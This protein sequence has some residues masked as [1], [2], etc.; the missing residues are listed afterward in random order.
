[1][2]HSRTYRGGGEPDDFSCLLHAQASEETELDN[3]RLACQSQR[4][5]RAP[6]ERVTSM[7]SPFGE[8]I[9]SSSVDLV[10]RI[11]RVQP[12]CV[13]AWSM[14]TGAS[15]APRR[16]R[17]GR[18]LPANVALLNQFRKAC[19]T[20]AVGRRVVVLP[21]APQVPGACLRSSAWTSGR[22]RSSARRHLC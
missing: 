4:D 18:D 9:A 7:G 12:F 1:M 19:S 6:I 22:V 5:A 10:L 13:R 14:S 8:F 20:C 17:S 11:R 21:L 15:T 3:A 2:L 16:R